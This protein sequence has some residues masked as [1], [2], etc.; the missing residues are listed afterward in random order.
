MVT[1]WF[2]FSLSVAHRCRELIENKC[3]FFGERFIAKYIETK[4]INQDTKVQA[5]EFDNLFDGLFMN[6]KIKVP[7][8]DSME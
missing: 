5:I 6:Y 8:K 7:P 4:N 2:S 3:T 1:V